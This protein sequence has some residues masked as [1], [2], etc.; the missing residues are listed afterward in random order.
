RHKN[1]YIGSLVLH[2]FVGGLVFLNDTLA[3]FY[4]LFVVLYFFN[5][6]IKA[7]K[8]KLT[9]EILWACAYLV[10]AEV[11]LRMNGGT[12]FYEAIKYLVIIFIAI[13]LFKN[14]FA[15]QSVIY[16]LYI[17]LLIP[18]IFVAV[19]QMGFETDIRKA[20]AFN[21]SG[22]VCLGIVAIFCYKRT[23]TFHQIKRIL[24]AFMFPLVSMMVYLFL[25]SPNLQEV[26][27]NTGSNFEASGG[28]GPNQVATVL[29][30]GIFVMATRY[31]ISKE[32][33]FHKG[34]DLLLLSLFG[35]RALVTFSRGGV[36][37]AVIMILF[38]LVLY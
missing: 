18:G 11:F 13:G 36:I 22:P 12:I 32:T 5:R 7:P 31:F 26:I 25:Y 27:T 10:G 20:I 35:F 37:T 21:L 6:L 3:K 19:T 28:F 15:N 38:F 8:Q 30:I 23:V 17:F 34:F 4:F 29:G 14:S 33:I 24:L 2:A 16:I 1:T 9:F